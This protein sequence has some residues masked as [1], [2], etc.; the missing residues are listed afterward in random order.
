M[1]ADQPPVQSLIQGCQSCCVAALEQ[2]A[3]ECRRC[4]LIS[5][6]CICAI[7]AVLHA[8]RHSK[9]KLTVMLLTFLIALQSAITT[10]VPQEPCPMSG[11][12]HRPS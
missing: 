10:A 7:S 6:L 4:R 8:V 9:S 11:L 3:D 1:Q 12:A 2:L 5:H